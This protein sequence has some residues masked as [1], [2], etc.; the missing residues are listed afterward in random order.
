MEEIILNKD[1]NKK[2]IRDK[3]YKQAEEFSG[4]LNILESKFRK[5]MEFNKFDSNRDGTIDIN[6]IDNYV[7]KIINYLIL[8]LLK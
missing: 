8:D 1:I 6:E 5:K 7:I 2:P 4:K 3:K